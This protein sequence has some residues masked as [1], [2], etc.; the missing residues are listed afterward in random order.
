MG[1]AIAAL[2]V[3]WVLWGVV[4]A[5]VEPANPRSLTLE[6]GL[7]R[8]KVERM[9]GELVQR[10]ISISGHTAANRR[11]DIKSEVRGKVIQVHK[12]KGEQVKQGDLLIELDKRD[13][14]ARVRQAEATFRQRKIELNSARQLKERGLSN[15]VQIVQA[16]TAMASA[17]AELTHARI[18]LDATLIRAPF[19]GI[20]DQQFVEMGDFVSENSMIATIL[21]F[22]P[23]L[24][25]GQ[26][27]ERDAAAIRIG[28]PAYAILVTGERVDGRIR[29]IAS[30]ADPQTR[31]F[32]IELEIPH[33]N[34]FASSGITARLHIPQPPTHAYF[35]S[36]ALLILN[37]RG[38]IGLKTIDEQHEVTFQAVQLLKADNNG[39]WVYGLGDQAD[40]IVVGQGFVDYRQRVEP[41]WVEATTNASDASKVK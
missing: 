10:D 18:Q 36:P 19:S 37:S 20:I 22:S 5:E 31:T 34:G 15:D 24:I 41:V 28:D 13:W 26:V 32:P 21:D 9:Q 33:L 16:E 1:G 25:K 23:L 14:P 40:I 12:R 2:L 35:I 17:E 11:V 6:Q 29:F 39:L 8:V 3:A 4:T 7:T 38:Q 30:E 27:P